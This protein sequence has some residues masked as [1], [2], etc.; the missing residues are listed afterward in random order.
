MNVIGSKIDIFN[1]E[2][3][4]QREYNRYELDQS[5]QINIHLLLVKEIYDGTGGLLSVHPGG[6]VRVRWDNAE[7]VTS[8]RITA[9]RMI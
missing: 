1:R 7:A 4:R 6:T 9:I 2:L 5:V 8:S 3:D